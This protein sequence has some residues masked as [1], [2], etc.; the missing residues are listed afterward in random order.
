MS[1]K[2]EYSLNFKE[3]DE[4]VQIYNN[5]TYLILALYN[6][7]VS[8]KFAW[9]WY[10][11]LEQRTLMNLINTN[12]KFIVAR[13]IAL[14][15]NYTDSILIFNESLIKECPIY[16]YF[17]NS[18]L[19]I[20]IDTKHCFQ[21]FNGAIT[22]NHL[23]DD[24]NIIKEDNLYMYSNE[25]EAAFNIDVQLQL[26]HGKNGMIQHHQQYKHQYHSRS[27][28]SESSKSTQF[29]NDSTSSY[30]NINKYN[31]KETDKKNNI[32][33]D[34]LFENNLTTSNKDLYYLNNNSIYLNDIE[35]IWTDPNNDNHLFILT[36]MYTLFENAFNLVY[37]DLL[38][39]HEQHSYLKLP[40]LQIA[41][42][43]R[44]E[45]VC[46]LSSII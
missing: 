40:V 11:S 23:I 21:I 19:Q 28:K 24:N 32:L 20:F 36:L 2:Q 16:P 44:K 35:Q 8:I 14:K 17:H 5:L 7:K 26:L 38:F 37:T 30:F 45:K 27:N 10:L 31:G 29:C 39:N 22:F 4:C 42:N 33:N 1:F 3:V 34:E 15:L 25:Q 6:E 46:S 41:Y 12:F 43:N 9:N 18:L 13:Y